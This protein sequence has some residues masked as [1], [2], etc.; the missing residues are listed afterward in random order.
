MS[1]GQAQHKVGS[2]HPVSRHQYPGQTSGPMEHMIRGITEIEP[3]P[4][5]MNRKEVFYLSKSWKPLLQT[6]KE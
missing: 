2:P 3:H 4:N 6:L 5:N 1:N